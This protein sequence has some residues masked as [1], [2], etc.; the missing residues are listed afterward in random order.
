M[1][2]LLKSRLPNGKFIVSPER[3]KNMAAVRGRGNKTTEVR[4]QMA[5]VRAG[6]RGWST[7]RTDLPGK[8]DFFFEAAKLAVFVDG[9]FWHGCNKCGHIP[10]TNTAFWTAKI[11]RNRKR[12]RKVAR[13][14]NRQSIR[15]FRLWEHQLREHL[16]RCVARIENHLSK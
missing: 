3:S 15:T 9:C 1:E 4:F 6:I 10:K 8:P 7:Q 2:R 11:E 13:L 14:L 5:L 16:E 12:H